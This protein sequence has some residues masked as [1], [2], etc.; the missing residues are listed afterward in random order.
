MSR[1]TLRRSILIRSVQRLLDDGEQVR[2]VVMLFTRH[3]WFWPYSLL[4]GAVIFLVATASGV[5]G[6]FNRVVLGACGL[7]IAGLA[8]TNHWVLAETS[9]GLVLLRSSRIRQY[10]RAVVQRLPEGLVPEMAGSTVITSDWRIEGVLYTLTKRW[11]P[12]MRR[13]ATSDSPGR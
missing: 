8:T 2:D 12:A 9:E 11:E 5:E 7:A 3:R 1:P 6:T 10:A 13:L 4:A